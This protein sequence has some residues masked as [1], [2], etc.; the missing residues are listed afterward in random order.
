MQLLDLLRLR[1]AEALQR[2]PLVQAS[3]TPLQDIVAFAQM[4]RPTTD[5]RHGDYQAN[6]AMPLGK[7]L[8]QN[9]RAVAEQ[10]V[11]TVDLGGICETP[12]IAG[13]ALST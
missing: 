1:F 5:T 10:L 2:L 3:E 7:K 6:M 8:G 11:A 12:E 9:P 4:V 13:P